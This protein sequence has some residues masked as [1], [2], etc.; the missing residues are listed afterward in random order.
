[1]KYLYENESLKFQTKFKKNIF[2]TL[3]IGIIISIGFYILSYYFQ[4]FIIEQFEVMSDNLGIAEEKTNTEKFFL[5]LQIIF[6]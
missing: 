4:D 1:M 5:Q 2:N 6:L 3:I